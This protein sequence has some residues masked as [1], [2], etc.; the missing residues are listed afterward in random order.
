MYRNL[1][2]S[3]DEIVRLVFPLVKAEKEKESVVTS[4]PFIVEK[5][6]RKILGVNSPFLKTR[7]LKDEN[8]EICFS[9]E[10]DWKGKVIH[11]YRKKEEP[12]FQC[13]GS[14]IYDITHQDKEISLHECFKFF[15]H[16]EVLKTELK[17]KNMTKENVDTFLNEWKIFGEK[18]QQINAPRV[19]MG[20]VLSDLMGGNITKVSNAFEGLEIV[21]DKE[22]DIQNLIFA[23]KPQ[24]RR[25]K[26]IVW[27]GSTE[28]FIRLFLYLY[29]TKAIPAIN[30]W[31]IK[32]YFEKV[33][34]QILEENPEIKLI[35]VY[36]K[37]APIEWSYL[38]RNL[39]ELF[40]EL[41]EL[42]FI[43]LKE[44]QRLLHLD[45]VLSRCFTKTNTISQLLKES[46]KYV[47]Y[48]EKYDQI[49]TKLYK[50]M[51]TDLLKEMSK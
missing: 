21:K 15:V 47:D 50:P 3:I 1:N 16:Y 41:S 25:A 44:G 34:M 18:M 22:E 33:D 32:E 8:G 6:Y 12:Q 2:H 48:K 39:A 36:E 17:D 42:G 43:G 5:T 45:N 28:E 23:R 14:S 24:R 51:F 46:S 40:V 9:Y 30:I 27:N 49:F 13:L 10:Y 11:E 29:K 4:R 35:S 26:T 19:D 7:I 31:V 37:D 20:E 38:Q